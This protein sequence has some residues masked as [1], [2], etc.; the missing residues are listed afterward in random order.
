MDN[1]IW[2]EAGLVSSTG[3]LIDQEAEKVFTSPADMHNHP[4]A[5]YMARLAPR[6]HRGLVTYLKIARDI[7]SDK[8]VPLAEFPLARLEY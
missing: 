7:L 6:T 4:V 5:T 1:K 3:M 2:I 8:P